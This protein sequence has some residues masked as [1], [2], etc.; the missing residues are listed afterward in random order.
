MRKTF[1]AVSISAFLLAAAC[2]HTAPAQAEAGFTMADR[3]TIHD[4]LENQDAAWNAGDIEG[5]MEGYWVSPELRF[6]SGGTVTR[7][8]EETLQ[9]YRDRYSNRALMGQL[10]FSE[11]EIVPLADDAAVVHGRWLLTRDADAP[12]GLFTLVFRKIDGHWKIIS[13][14]TTSAD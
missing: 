13:D 6:A 9:R 12:S 8:Y 11:L 14:T 5:F 3:T 1:F 2:S 4:L 10:S 7:G